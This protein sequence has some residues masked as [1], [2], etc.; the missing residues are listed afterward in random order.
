MPAAS[1]PFR[2]LSPAQYAALS[3]KEKAEYLGR[4]TFDVQEHSRQFRARNK[5]LVE[6]LLR[7][8]GV[9]GGK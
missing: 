7:K 3:A 9:G 5:R 1:P 2:L 4:L 8:D 6:W